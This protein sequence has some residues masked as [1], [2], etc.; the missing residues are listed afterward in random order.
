MAKRAYEC[1]SNSENL[2]VLQKILP[3]LLLQSKVRCIDGQKGSGCNPNP[4]LWLWEQRLHTRHPM[5]H[6]TMMRPWLTG[7]IS[8]VSGMSTHLLMAYFL[9]HWHPYRGRRQERARPLAQFMPFLLFPF[10]NTLSSH[11]KIK[12]DSWIPIR[13]QGKG[14]YYFL[15]FLLAKKLMLSVSHCSAHHPVWTW[16]KAEWRCASSCVPCP[17]NN[18]VSAQRYGFRACSHLLKILVASSAHYPN[19]SHWMPWESY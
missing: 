12:L 6:P 15:H 19:E 18:A 13:F 10:P 1:L 2:G 11:P 3:S 7:I 4:L 8:T 17:L 16:L 9:P 14:K 5:S